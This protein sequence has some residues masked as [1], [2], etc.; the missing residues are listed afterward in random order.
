MKE[1]TNPY[2]GVGLYTI[3]EA[4][5]LTGVSSQR[6]RRWLQGYDYPFKGN[7]KHMSSLWTPEVPEIHEENGLTFKDLLEIRFIDV[8]LN[9]GVSMKNIRAAAE[10]ACREYRQAYPF[11]SQKFKTDGKRI[12]SEITEKSGDKKLVDL[13]KGQ[14][15]FNKVIEPSLKGVE[16]STDGIAE[17]WFHPFG[18]SKE[19]VLDPE[20]S[21]GRPIIFNGGVPTDILASAYD[22]DEDINFVARCYGVNPKSVKA[23]IEFEEKLAA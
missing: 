20:R 22:S 2:I 19:I 14:W 18:K 5:R 17:R 11:S 23:A 7:K 8:F 16:F 10:L 3:P 21:F 9:H 4:S 1:R 12:F 13:I 6:I 15:T